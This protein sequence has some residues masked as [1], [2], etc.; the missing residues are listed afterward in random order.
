N[1]SFFFILF[2]YIFHVCGNKRMEIGS[3][4]SSEISSPE[5]PVQSSQET[6]KKRTRPDVSARRQKRKVMQTSCITTKWSLLCK[7]EFLRDCP[8][9]IIVIWNKVALEAYQFANFHVLRCF[10]EEKPLPVLDQGFFMHCC[11]AITLQYETKILKDPSMEETKQLWIR[12]RQEAEITAVN[13]EG[14]SL[15]MTA[16]PVEMCTA[17]RN[18]LIVNFTS[19]LLRWLHLL[20]GLNRSEACAFINGAFDAPQEN[21]TSIQQ[22]LVDFLQFR[23]S[24]FE[25]KRHFNHF[26]G[27]T[28]QFA[29]FMEERLEEAKDDHKAKRGVRTF[30]ILPL[31]QSFVLSHIPLNNTTLYC[32]IQWMLKNRLNQRLRIGNQSWTANLS[33][34]QFKATRNLFWHGLFNIRPFETSTRK[35]AYCITTNGYSASLHLECPKRKEDEDIN[36]PFENSDEDDEDVQEKRGQSRAFYAH[37]NSICERFVGCD[38]GISNFYVGVDQDGQYV[39]AS[40]QE[41]RDMSKM[42]QQIFWND[43]LRRRFPQYDQVL[44]GMPSLHV[45]DPMEF[46]NRV[47]YILRHKDSLFS[48]CRQKGFRKW[49][50]KTKR[51]Y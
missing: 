8:E 48:F 40:T 42:K 47:R 50:F 23:P 33:D 20:W 36:S 19:R 24:E 25:I 12:N 18:H 27:L 7:N 6:K 43:N 29:K 9:N 26:L 46:L 45:T 4:K 49:R 15:L 35:F 16:L 1:S 32:I 22:G 44:R 21:R 14:L 17:S 28:F 10:N 3:S 38:P 34:A 30:S 41:Y 13:I 39:K 11:N 31:K 5:L 37:L 51:F 2:L